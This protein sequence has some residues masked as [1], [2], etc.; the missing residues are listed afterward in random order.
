MEFSSGDMAG[1]EN[2]SKLMVG[3]PASHAWL[4]EGSKGW[5]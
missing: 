3:F 4:L 2:S 5:T 1:W